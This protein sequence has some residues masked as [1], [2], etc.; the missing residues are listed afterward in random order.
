MII[1]DCQQ[2]TTEWIRERL[3]RLTASE[4][5]SNI[6]ETTG[7]LSKSKA[8]IGAIDKLIAG[9]E[10][11][12]VMKLREKEL[13]NMDDWELKKFMSHYVG[14]IFKGNH[15]TERGHDLENEAV[16]K[17]SERT[18]IFFEDVGMC[19]IGDG[20]SPGYVSGSPDGIGRNSQNVI[21]SGC[22]LKNANLAKFNGMVADQ[23]IHPDYK[24]QV[25]FSMAVCELESW[26]FGANFKGKDLFHKEVKRDSYTD[27][28]EKS[29]QGFIQMYAERL[30]QVQEGYAIIKAQ[31]NRSKITNKPTPTIESI[32]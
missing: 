7:A 14:D 3:W 11:A 18:G 23:E 2:G 32:I 28:V 20:S 26:H 27:A 10:L 13:A 12:K 4:A 25:H 31:A 17:L 15:H 19:V 22:E 6:S 30:A 1:L 21:V 8:A 9:M 5:K 16:A 24:L 29:I